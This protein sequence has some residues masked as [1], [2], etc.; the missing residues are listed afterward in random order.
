MKS[1]NLD[2]LGVKEMEEIK[3]LEVNGGLDVSPWWSVAS[4]II[5]AAYTVIKEA[6]DAYIDYSV[7]TGGKYVIHHAV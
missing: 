7:K 5:Q 2:A 1:F 4:V 6:A 3:L